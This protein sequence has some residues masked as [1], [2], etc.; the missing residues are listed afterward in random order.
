MVQ[1]VKLISVLRINFCI[2]KKVLLKSHFFGYFFD[3][4]N[5]FLLSDFIKKY[6]LDTEELNKGTK[7]NFGKYINL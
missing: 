5:M 2:A 7:I 3:E 1:G 4:N 6:E